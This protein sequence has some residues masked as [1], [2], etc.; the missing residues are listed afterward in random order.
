MTLG[1]GLRQI[2]YTLALVYALKGCTT[3]LD[4][5]TPWAT[6]DVTPRISTEPA[7]ITLLVTIPRS[8]QNRLLCVGYDGPQFRSSCQEHVGLEAAYR[9][10]QAFS[11]LPAGEYTAV[12]EVVRDEEEKGGRNQLITTQFVV[13]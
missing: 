7:T 8:P 1:R 9:V 4:A 2:A 12:A 5:D 6:L 10:E 13:N 3:I 11:G